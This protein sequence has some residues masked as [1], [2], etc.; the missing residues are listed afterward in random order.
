MLTKD[1]KPALGCGADE[2]L[3]GGDGVAVGKESEKSASKRTQIKGQKAELCV[4][5]EAS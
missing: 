5:G 1:R 3:S 2:C 4:H